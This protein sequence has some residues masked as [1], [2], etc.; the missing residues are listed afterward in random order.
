MASCY[1]CH[2]A[3]GKTSNWIGCEYC[4]EN[5]A[6]LKCAYLEG[7]KTAN[8]AKIN[9]MCEHCGELFRKLKDKAEVLAAAG[10]QITGNV[11]DAV[12]GMIKEAKDEII[13][14]VEEVGKFVNPSYADTLKKKV[15]RNEKNLVIVE[16]ADDGL[17][18]MR[19]KKEEVARALDGVQIMDTRFTNKK[20][21]MN[22][23]TER[24]MNNATLRLN[25]I[26]TLAAKNK[27]RKLTP[28]IMICN[29]AKDE[30]KKFVGKSD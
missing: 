9:W 7:V 3:T 28:K 22:F 12:S 24:E 21:V 15:R 23:A 2:L 10:C 20:I 29:V 6:H 1:V 18:D 26:E 14:K 27:K 16:S 17:A 25:G 11:T 5:W 19:E 4:K 30:S 8:I 13:L